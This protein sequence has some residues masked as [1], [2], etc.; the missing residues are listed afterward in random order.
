METVFKADRCEGEGGGT[1][2]VRQKWSPQQVQN[3]WRE[4]TWRQTILHGKADRCE[5][6]GGGETILVRQKWSPQQ[7]WNVQ[8]E[9]T[10]RQ[11]ILETFFKVDVREKGEQK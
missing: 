10:C 4:E 1:I 11:T 5:G 8:R 7:V 3:V 6:E 2:L 9:E